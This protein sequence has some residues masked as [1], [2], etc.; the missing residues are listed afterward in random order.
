MLFNIQVYLMVF[1][2]ASCSSVGEYVGDKIIDFSDTPPNNVDYQKLINEGKKLLVGNIEIY[3][4][5]QNITRSCSINFKSTNDRHS[6]NLLY[7][8]DVLIPLESN[9][10]RIDHVRCVKRKDNPYFFYTF[11]EKEVSFNENVNYFGKIRIFYTS[12]EK[13]DTYKKYDRSSPWINEIKFE[14]DKIFQA[15]FMGKYKLPAAKLFS[16]L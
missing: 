3:F 5:G 2:V 8:G 7:E 11:K 14:N 9:K 1:F 10:I 4:D 15:E 6:M 12:K 16:L 13:V